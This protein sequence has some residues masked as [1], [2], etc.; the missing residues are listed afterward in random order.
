MRILRPLVVA[1]L[2]VGVHA[3]AIAQAVWPSDPER[4]QVGNTWPDRVPSCR[5]T[6]P[7]LTADSLGPIPLRST[8][9]LADLRAAC[10]SWYHAWRFLEGQ[11]T[12]VLMTRLGDVSVLIEVYD[13]LATSRVYRAA[14]RSPAAR[15]ADG[16]GPGVLARMAAQRWAPVS[17]GQ[18]EGFVMTS[19]SRPWISLAVHIP[20]VWD[21]RLISRLVRTKDARLLPARATISEVLLLPRR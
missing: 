4:N 9:T 6:T 7:L 5:R 8:T 10:E 19:P 21:Q 13:T 2:L 15:T 11:A 17:F 18:G 1:S 12:P 14:T 16:V 3:P 20:G